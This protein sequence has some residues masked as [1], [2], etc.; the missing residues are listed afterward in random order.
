MNVFKERN[1]MAENKA[2]KSDAL[3]KAVLV[4]F[5]SLLSFSI[6]TFVG[7]KFSDNQN[8]TAKLS[9]SHEDGIDK[10]VSLSH[11]IDSEPKSEAVSDEQVVKAAEEFVSD[12]EGSKAENTKTDE[13]AS[14]TTS[15]VTH[16]P[17]AG[18]IEAAQSHHNEESGEAPAQREIAATTEHGKT[19]HG[20]I[21]KEI[22]HATANLAVDKTPPMTDKQKTHAAPATTLPSQVA[23]SPIGKLTVQIASFSTEE[24]A[25]KKVTEIRGFGFDSF[26]TSVK[27][28]GKNWYRVNV[29]MFPTVAEGEK[30]IAELKEKAQ[31]KTGF[32][33]KMVQ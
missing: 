1:P 15:E 10:E 26:F 6:G 20:K 33:Q 32:I 28:S 29:G 8:K 27:L 5:I 11:S 16:E 4:F 25:K 13:P 31:I 22:S 17:P 19:E 3:V 14:E 30:L 18:H 12:D 7:K 9:G 2:S 23:K 24:E 21:D